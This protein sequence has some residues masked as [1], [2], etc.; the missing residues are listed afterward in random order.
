MGVWPYERDLARAQNYRE[1]IFTTASQDDNEW[2]KMMA[3]RT[4]RRRLFSTLSLLYAVCRL[5][6]GL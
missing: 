5:G 2:L 1:L 3:V 6:C 4:V